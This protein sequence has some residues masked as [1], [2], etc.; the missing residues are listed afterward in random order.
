MLPSSATITLLRNAPLTGVGRMGERLISEKI[1]KKVGVQ[2]KTV[3]Q[4]L[5]H[6]ASRCTA[7]EE[8]HLSSL[9]IET[10]L[11]NSKTVSIWYWELKNKP[12]VATCWA[13]ELFVDVLISQ[14][15]ANIFKPKIATTMTSIQKVKLQGRQ[16]SVFIL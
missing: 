12:N 9:F 3:A 10:T 13:D 5:T 2:S 4:A 8:K 16:R 15:T 14:F 1:Q 11:N 7:S 6:A